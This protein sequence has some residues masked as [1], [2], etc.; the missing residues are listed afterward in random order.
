M[1]LLGANKTMKPVIESVRAMRME[2]N[3]YHMRDVLHQC[4]QSKCHDNMTLTA[5][6]AGYLRVILQSNVLSWMD[7]SPSE[8]FLFACPRHVVL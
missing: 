1:A 8:M 6:I 7:Y 3:I 2:E 5:K 4:S